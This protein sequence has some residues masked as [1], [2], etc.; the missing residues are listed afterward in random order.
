MQSY[1]YCIVWKWVASELLRIYTRMGNS[2][3]HIQIFKLSALYSM[4]YIKRIWRWHYGNMVPVGA[5]RNYSVHA[6]VLPAPLL[7]SGTGRISVHWPM[8]HTV[9]ASLCLSSLKFLVTCNSTACT[10]LL[11]SRTGRNSQTSIRYD[12]HYIKQL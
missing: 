8:H 11:Q 6:R 4:Y 1:C 3:R 12:I 2:D 7:P 9:H 10:S 5:V